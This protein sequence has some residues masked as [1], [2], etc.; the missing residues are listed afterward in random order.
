MAAASALSRKTSEVLGVAMFAASLLWIVSLASYS[1]ADP[2]WFFNST[3]ALPPENFIGR[4]G[5]FV[6]ELS[7]QLFG[8]SAFMLPGVLVVLGWHYFWCRDIDAG[9]T[10]LLGAFLLFAC[11]SSFLALAV[12][13][14]DIGGK[15]MPA[16]GIVGKWM[17]IGL[18]ASLNRAGSITY[19]RE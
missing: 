9:Y 13:N 18:T 7:L 19:F 15:L 11:V 4:V 2:V 14:V 10:K 3:S 6:A 17:A 1:P 16:G 12:D 8:Y 5:A